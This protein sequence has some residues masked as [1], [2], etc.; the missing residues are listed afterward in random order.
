MKPACAWYGQDKHV[1]E[2]VLLVM[3]PTYV[4]YVSNPIRIGAQELGAKK[5][6]H[7]CAD[8]QATLPTPS[9]VL[10]SENTW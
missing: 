3:C 2:S 7:A 10:F 4:M 6:C 1:E 5:V 8:P 9:E